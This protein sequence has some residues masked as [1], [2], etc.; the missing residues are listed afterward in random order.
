MVSFLFF[1]LREVYFNLALLGNTKNLLSL[2]FFRENTI[3]S[4]LKITIYMEKIYNSG[5]VSGVCMQK[6]L[7][8]EDVYIVYIV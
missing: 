1:L 6:C 5:L 3:K 4:S 7:W 2:E 8:I